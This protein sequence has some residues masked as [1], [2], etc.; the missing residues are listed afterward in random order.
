MPKEK[1]QGAQIHHVAGSFGLRLWMLSSIA[2][3]GG[4][5]EA[6]H[7]LLLHT[8]RGDWLGD[9]RVLVR[10]MPSTSGVFN[11]RGYVLRARHPAFPSQEGETTTRMRPNFASDRRS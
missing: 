8:A 2:V 3:L 11:W 7:A 6:L 10:R 1:P 9:S 5:V 4:G